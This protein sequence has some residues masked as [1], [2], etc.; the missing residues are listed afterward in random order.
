[1]LLFSIWLFRWHIHQ[2]LPVGLF[3]EATSI[4][5]LCQCNNELFDNQHYGLAGKF[6]SRTQRIRDH[7]FHD[8]KWQLLND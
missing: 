4:G 2:G 8:C 1:M 3:G 7:L 6:N 5:L